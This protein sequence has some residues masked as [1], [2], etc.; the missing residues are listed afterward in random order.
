MSYENRSAGV[1]SRLPRRRNIGTGKIVEVTDLSKR[2]FLVPAASQS[3]CLKLATAILSWSVG[4]SC[5]FVDM[6]A[7]ELSID[8]LFIMPTLSF[9]TLPPSPA[10]SLTLHCLSNVAGTPFASPVVAL[11]GRFSDRLDRIGL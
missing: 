5:G 8:R 4:V 3:V 10:V 11:P 9:C 6:S 1:F 2:C 7:V